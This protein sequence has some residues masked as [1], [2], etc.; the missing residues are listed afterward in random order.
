LSKQASL[1]GP[2]LEAWARFLGAHAGLIRRLNAEL[3]AEHGLTLND[4]EVLLRLARAP[5]RA[6]RRVDLA[7]SVFLTAS[8][9]TRLLAGLEQAGLVERAE[10]PSDA[11]V[12]YAVLTAAGKEKLR[13]ASPTHVRGVNELFAQRFSTTELET[14]ALLLGRLADGDPEAC[15]AE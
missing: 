15:S 2:A 3:V 8:G 1:E 10:C 6:M 14:L 12:T 7:N 11:R 5:E 4:Y 13:E 9:M